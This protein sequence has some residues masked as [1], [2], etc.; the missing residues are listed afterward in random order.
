MRDKCPKCGEPLVD[1]PPVGGFNNSGH[2]ER[3]GC[4]TLTFSGDSRYLTESPECLRRQLAQANAAQTPPRTANMPPVEPVGWIET[5]ETLRSQ[6]A[7]GALVMRDQA[8]T[9][10]R[11]GTELA[12]HVET[13]ERLRAALRAGLEPQEDDP[14]WY[15]HHGPCQAHSL[16]R[17][18][19]GEPE[20]E[21]AMM[22]AALTP[23]TDTPTTKETAK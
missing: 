4:G 19:A 9:I 5:N 16:R 15:D 12:E 6:L 18:D 13:I 2:Y 17:N 7:T 14:C 11:L 20:C 23:S 3:Y 1:H 22:R 21:V 8:E 10:E